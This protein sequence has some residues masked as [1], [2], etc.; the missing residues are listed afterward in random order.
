MGRPK[1]R[2]C[3]YGHDTAVSGR[4]TNSACR[5]CVLGKDDPAPYTPGR[6]GRKKATSCKR[7]HPRTPANVNGR[8]ACRVCAREHLRGVQIRSR[9]EG[10]HH[11]GRV[12]G[13]SGH[14]S[15]EPVLRF[16][17]AAGIDNVAFGQR[18]ADAFG[19]QP[20]SG[21]QLLIR[22]RKSG[23]V[24]LEVADA[25]CVALGRHPFEVYGPDWFR[26]EVADAV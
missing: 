20:E 14:V 3:K 11:V 9:S 18:Y 15:A 26:E 25:M 6:V 21:Q 1:A 17:E 7:G 5:A 22:A 12:R 10:I 19:I 4:Y 8:G 23:R 2:F 24:T 16:L 13:T